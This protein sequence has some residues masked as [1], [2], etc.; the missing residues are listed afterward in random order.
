MGR[1]TLR[2]ESR[3]GIMGQMEIGKVIE[4]VREGRGMKLKDLA[5]KMGYKT[6]MRGLSAKL[7][8]AHSMSINGAVEILGHLGYKLVAMPEDVFTDPTNMYRISVDDDKEKYS[9]PE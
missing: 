9:K 2:G 3:E 7:K 1:G 5:E 4:E 6:G 8:G